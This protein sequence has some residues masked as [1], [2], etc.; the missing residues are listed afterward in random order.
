[1]ATER[2]P[3]DL[4]AALRAVGAE[5]PAAVDV[6]AGFF[7]RTLARWL[8]LPEGRSIGV[9]DPVRWDY[10][11]FWKA[12]LEPI[13]KDGDRET[14]GA[15]LH[16]DRD[17]PVERVSWFVVKDTRGRILQAGWLSAAP[18]L[19]AAAADDDLIAAPVL[20]AATVA[21]LVDENEA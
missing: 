4:A 1:M 18:R 21:R 19:V 20:D 11:G 13:A 9:K 6:D 15:D 2:D 7:H 3:L 14:W 12:T 17:G 10:G 8:G 5:A 16:R